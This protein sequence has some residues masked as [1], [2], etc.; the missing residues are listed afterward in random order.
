MPADSVVVDSVP[1]LEA[2][3]VVQQLEGNGLW[4][5]W[6]RGMR[7]PCVREHSDQP[8]PLCTRCKS[9][10]FFTFRPAGYELPT[11]L[12]NFTTIQR[13]MID[14][15][16]LAVIKGHFQEGNATGVT[17]DPDGSHDRGY[18]ALTV[19][20]ENQLGHRDV[21]VG[22]DMLMARDDLFTSN[23][24]LDVLQWPAVEVEAVFTQTT[25]Y[26]RGTDYAID[27]EGRIE[28][29][30][31]GQSPTAGSTVSISYVSHPFYRVANR[32]HAARGTNIRTGD[33]AELGSSPHGWRTPTGTAWAGP[34]R[35][36]LALET[37]P[38]SR[39]KWG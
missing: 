1:S 33:F 19:R 14:E 21:L 3:D 24:E 39:R 31:G 12:T 20:G 2:T 28:W 17:F 7:C 36:L 29:L 10:G 11:D 26:T 32:P 35:A 16:S 25:E 23:G 34:I 9:T 13:H 37:T 38:R 30:A 27:V 5:G 6:A 4:W 8:D 18:G 22:L 15:F